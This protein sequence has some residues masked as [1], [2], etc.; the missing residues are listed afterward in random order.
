MLHLKMLIYCLKCGK[1]TETNDLKDAVVKVSRHI[2]TGTCKACG[3]K[4]S[5]FVKMDWM[6]LKNLQQSQ[7]LRNLQ[8]KSQLLRNLQQRKLKR[9]KLLSH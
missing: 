2:T 3:T 9:N 1:K 5:V 7:L 6:G 4:K 8:P